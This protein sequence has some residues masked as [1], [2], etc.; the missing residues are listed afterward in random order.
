[1]NRMAKPV[2]IVSTTIIPRERAGMSY[3]VIIVGRQSVKSR[4]ES[5]VSSH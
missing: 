3:H 1:M 4:N 5:L 2:K